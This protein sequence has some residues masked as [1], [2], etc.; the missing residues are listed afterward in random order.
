MARE[1]LCKVCGKWH[2]L[3]E[4]WPDN[5]WRERAPARSDLSAPMIIHDNIQ[6]I[7]SMA[8][9]KVYTSKAAMRQSYMP[10]GNPD[11]K[12]YIEVGD[13]APTQRAAKP[14]PDRKAIK[15]TVEKA[16]SRAGLGA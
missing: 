4:A 9:G 6:P 2:S 3:D 5:C 14:K 12:R 10:S 8:D 1:R 16:F 15:E 13:E 11:G 7:R